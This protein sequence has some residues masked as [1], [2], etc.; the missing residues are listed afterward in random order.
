MFSFFQTIQI[1]DSGIDL[2]ELSISEKHTVC[3]SLPFSL[4][5]LVKKEYIDTI[6]QIFA[7]TIIV[8]NACEKCQKKLSLNVDINNITDVIKVLFQNDSALNILGK[9]ANVSSNCHL[10]Y[11]FYNNINPLELDVLYDM[12][13]KNSDPAPTKSDKDVNLFDEFKLNNSEMVETPS[14]FK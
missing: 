10:D 2:N 3:A 4:M 5:S 7:N 11:N 14:E 1:Y 13:R 8:E 12:T 9:Y 6:H